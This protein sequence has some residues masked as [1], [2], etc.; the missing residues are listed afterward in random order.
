M[1]KNAIVLALGAATA[2]AQSPQRTRPQDAQRILSVLAADSME[3]RAT[4]SRGAKKAATYIANVMRSLR[5]EPLGDSGFFQRVPMSLDSVP[6][7]GRG[8]RGGA[9]TDSTRPRFAWRVRARGS[10]A[11]HDTIPAQRRR[12]DYNVLG[13]IRGS[14]PA[15]RNEYVLVGAHHDHIGIIAP[16]NGDSI[17]NGADDDASGVTAILEIARQLKQGRAPRRSVI[18][19]ATTGEEVGYFGTNWLLAHPP[20]PLDKIVADIQIEMI[21]RPDSL[22]NGSG[23]GWLTGY[24]RST[25]GEIFA[26]NKL[27]IVADRR[28]DQDFFFRSDNIAYARKGIVAHTLASFNLHTDYHRVTDDVSRVDFAHMAALINVATDAVR[29]LAVGA[30]PEWK[31]GGRPQ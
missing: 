2:T 25:M 21:G 17:A 28:L 16:E 10:F 31:T 11:D 20:V 23:K 14:D 30:K 3:G 27:P 24:E 9:T 6:I 26:A 19:A 7:G 15:L 5:L 18:F 4:A 8:G 22:S 13:I 1:L 29:L 12:I